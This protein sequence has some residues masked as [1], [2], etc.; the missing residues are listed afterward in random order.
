M[1]ST[2]LYKFRSGTS[3]EPLPLP[4]TSARLFDIKRAI[5]RAKGLDGGGGGPTLEFD[6]S[7]R[8]ASTDEVY[9]DESM[10]LPR[11]T[12]IVVRRVAAERGRGILSRIAGQGGGG[13]TSSS[14]GGGGGRVNN[15]AARD[16]FYT[17]RS[18]D[19]DAD[20]EFVDSSAPIPPPPSIGIGG[21][22]PAQP[23]AEVN[24]SREL[25]A[26]RAVTDQ[27]GS[28]YGAS[29][30]SSSSPPPK[31]HGRPNADPELRQQ[32]MMGAPQPKKRA[33]GIPRTFLT[34][35]ANPPPSAGGEGGVSADGPANVG[36][37]DGGGTAGDEDGGQQQPQGNLAAQLQ[38][39]AQAFQ[40]LVRS[41]GGQSLTSSSRRR[42]LDYA[43]KLTATSVPEHLQCGICHSIVKS[44][45]LVPWDT[46][47]GRS[48]CESCIRDGL[49]K[50]GFTCPLTGTEGVSPDDLFPN[51]GLRKAADAFV[52]DVMA[53]MDAI[54]KQIEAEQEEEERKRVAAVAERGKVG[55]GNDFDDGKDGIVLGRRAK[56]S[57]KKRKGGVNDDLL[58]GG[59]DEFGGD[60]FDVAV[61]D[62]DDD[63]EPEDLDETATAAASLAID[64]NAK[65]ETMGGV[66]KNDG[67]NEIVDAANVNRQASNET[68]AHKSD[69]PDADD[70]ASAKDR[71]KNSDD[72]VPPSPTKT[73][74]PRAVRKEAPKR[75]GPPAGYVLG[76]AGVGG[77]GAGVMTS[78]PQNVMNNMMQQFPPPPPPPPPPMRVGGPPV[79]GDMGR[80]GG[81][82]GMGGGGRFHPGRF[83][84]NHTQQLQP[85]PYHHHQQPQPYP[86]HNGAGRG[87]IGYAN[88]Q[89][90]GRGGGF[91]GNQQ[92]DEN[93][94]NGNDWN[95]KRPLDAM[96]GPLGSQGGNVHQWRGGGEPNH[97]HGGGFPHQGG[98]WAPGG[99]GGPRDFCYQGRGGAFNSGGRFLGGG[100]GGFD[101]RGGGQ[102]NG[103]RGHF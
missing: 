101:G 91:H 54:E 34:L 24:E 63:D 72:A 96:I 46:A 42:D 22:A 38:P 81:G 89:G 53:K 75:R 55:S 16:G 74:G 71:P 85:F 49:T 21:G 1:T 4:G 44:A 36:G 35:G 45:M 33:T 76:P 100:R 97:P 13:G 25:E 70:D 77:G 94:N 64:D 68:N 7:I 39:S 84:P 14:H 59:D 58:F 29:S 20:D 9:D 69:K 61:D 11:G 60:V 87:P 32:E 103:G 27:A 98:G 50:N 19:R 12:R 73:T 2:I 26:L 95:R 30:S 78:P 6:L 8:N 62:N 15:A 43:L 66:A 10:I 65:T 40:A 82:R 79:Q 57:N 31:F 67:K 86:P 52:R 51:V 90:G 3:F 5:V 48:T 83:N 88:Q 99:G 102:W 18:R 17:I 23:T 47:E 80:G 93:N 92:W 37:G 56:R 28:V 41:G